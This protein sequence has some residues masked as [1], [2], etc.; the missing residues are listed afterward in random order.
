M[1]GDDRRI[2]GNLLGEVYHPSSN[3]AMN[4]VLQPTKLVKCELSSQMGGGFTNR[5]DSQIGETMKSG[6]EVNLKLI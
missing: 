6:R 1:S 5:K 4:T 2:L 3:R